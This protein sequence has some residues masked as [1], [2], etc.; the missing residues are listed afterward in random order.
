MKKFLLLIFPAGA[1]LVVFFWYNNCLNGPLGSLFTDQA[2]LFMAFGRLAGIIAALGVMGQLLLISRARWLEPLFGLDRLTRVHHF[3]GLII[4]LA[5]LVHPP[6]V[7]W[8]HALQTGTAFFSQ[9]L[10]V[11]KWEDILPAAAGEALIL[12][13]VLL[14]LPFTRRRLS[15]EAWHRAHLGAYAGL[16]LSIGHQLE[17]GGDIAA[18]LRYFAWTWYCLLAFTGLTVLW[19]RLLRPLWVYKKHGFTVDRTVMETADIMSVYIKGNGL[20]NFPVEAGQFALLRFW[21]PGFKLQAHPFSFSKCADGKELRFSIKKLGDFTGSLH[22]G[23]KRGVP[24]IIDG[25]HGVF[26]AARMRTDKALLVA[27][28]IGI[29]PL[30]ALAERLAWQKK[31][32]VLVFSNRGRKDIAFETELAGLEKAGLFRA[33][34]VLSEDKEWAGE[35]GRVDAVYLKRLVPDFLERDAFLCGPPPMMAALNSGLKALGLPKAQIHF[36]V[37]SL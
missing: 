15:Y 12:I 30:R 22:A 18:E 7:V 20:E 11:L 1:L 26:T 33:V 19:Y 37:F 13:A 21:A 23:L 34:H 6:L 8:S 25:P 5:L 2:G 17:L 16:A 35:K 14:S 32:C 36:E 27:G 10:A 3:A 29:T 31:D 4:P 24:V 28:G 9:Y